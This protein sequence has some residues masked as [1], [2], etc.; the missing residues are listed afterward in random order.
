[1]EKES[2]LGISRDWEAETRGK[3]QDLVIEK[4]AGGE[5]GT[6]YLVVLGL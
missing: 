4:V 1:M 3:G 2:K 6:S 5:F